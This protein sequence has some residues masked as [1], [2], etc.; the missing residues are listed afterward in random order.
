MTRGPRKGSG[1]RIVGTVQ[2]PS[3]TGMRG[4]RKVG[5]KSTRGAVQG[6]VGAGFKPGKPAGY[7]PKATVR[8]TVAV[9]TTRRNPSGITRKR[10]SR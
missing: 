5:G 2:T 10:R 9:G 3:T 8:P 4:T 7:K 6:K 1:K